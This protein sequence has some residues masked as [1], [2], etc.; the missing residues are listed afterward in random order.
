MITEANS[1]KWI[2]FNHTR[3]FT[4]KNGIARRQFRPLHTDNLPPSFSALTISNSTHPLYHDYVL[5]VD[6][7][8]F[9]IIVRLRP[10][11]FYKAE[12][13]Q[14]NGQEKV[15]VVNICMYVCD[16]MDL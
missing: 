7:S 9:I 1:I 16:E 12:N 10:T 8:A 11:L 13:L 4:Y 2:F 6:H 15:D 14:E 3:T 5:V